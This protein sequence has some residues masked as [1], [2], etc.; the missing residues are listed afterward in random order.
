MYER[1]HCFFCSSVFTFLHIGTIKNI[2]NYIST[3]IPV[4]NIPMDAQTAVSQPDSV[5]SSLDPHSD[6]YSLK[7]YF[8]TDFVESLRK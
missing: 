7:K 3:T 5:V 1:E 6:F 2:P 4:C 8:V